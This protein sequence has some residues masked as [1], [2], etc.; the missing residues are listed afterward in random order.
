[1]W[2]D[3]PPPPVAYLL[4]APLPLATGRF[5]AAAL[6]RS[7]L[8][9][10]PTFRR[11]PCSRRPPGKQPTPRWWTMDCARSPGFGRG[12]RQSRASRWSSCVS[13]C[14]PLPSRETPAASDVPTAVP[15]APVS[16]AAIWPAECR[17]PLPRRAA[18]A[19]GSCRR[20]R[21]NFHCPTTGR[22]MGPRCSATPYPAISRN[23][24]IRQRPSRR[25]LPAVKAP[26]VPVARPAGQPRASAPATP[27]AELPDAPANPP[28]VEAPTSS[29]R[30]EAQP[31][32]K[33]P[34]EV[35]ASAAA[36]RTSMQRTGPSSGKAKSDGKSGGAGESPRSPGQ[37]AL[38]VWRWRTRCA[39]HGSGA[40]R[41]GGKPGKERPLAVVRYPRARRRRAGTQE[42]RRG[43]T[44]SDS[45]PRRI[46]RQF[47]QG[48]LCRAERARAAEEARG[49][50]GGKGAGGGGGGKGK[51]GGRH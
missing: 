7:L 39:R 37:R 1:M 8:A 40:R 38:E 19:A 21:A 10:R 17:D 36:P 18:A 24:C 43:A 6:R 26:T 33:V 23:R 28:A 22:P 31:A 13:G 50:G 4:P 27:V 45:E 35:K 48:R 51:G 49:G 9:P 34:T 14:Q 42:L 29:G 44:R 46:A 47:R 11:R 2:H 15:P 12:F 41:V 20:R 25:R 16:R 30:A 5:P 3:L 32:A